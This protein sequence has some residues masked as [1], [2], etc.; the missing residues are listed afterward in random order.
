[1]H[2][3]KCG[4][5]FSKTDMFCS[6]CGEKKEV[7]KTRKQKHLLKSLIIAFAIIIVALIIFLYIGHN[8]MEKLDE[9][10]Q[11]GFPVF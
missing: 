10:L 5:K 1:M 6:A 11:P 2:C 7:V 3:D 9:V 8:V 4:E